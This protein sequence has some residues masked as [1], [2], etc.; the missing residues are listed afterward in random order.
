MANLAVKIYDHQKQ[1]DGRWKFT[2]VPVR[3]DPNK[4]AQQIIAS[5]PHR[6][7]ARA[8]KYKISWYEG[9]AKKFEAG[10]YE[11]LSEA[12]RAAKFRQVQ[13]HSKNNGVVI[14]DP[15]T[16][17]AGRLTIDI[18]ALAY[19]RTVEKEGRPGTLALAKFD[20]AEF[21]DW[22]AGR[23]GSRRSFVDQITKDDMLDFRNMIVK[24]GRAPRTAVNKVSLRHGRC[25]R[26]SSEATRKRAGARQK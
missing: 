2:P 8:G 21:Q 5:T 3:I 11:L 10:S 15:K 9:S 20:L 23:K 6:H 4:A 25:L 12:V 1:K 16:K 22:N 24:S 7:G 13:L 17:D 14:E 18:A 19:L 26:W